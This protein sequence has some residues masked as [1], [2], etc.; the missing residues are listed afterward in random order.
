[1]EV[2]ESD[3]DRFAKFARL[4]MDRVR[5]LNEKTDVEELRAF[6]VMRLWTAEQRLTTA[7]G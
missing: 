6:V 7:A 5:N 4:K 3:F 2:A 1:M